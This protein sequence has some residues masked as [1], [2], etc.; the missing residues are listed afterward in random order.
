[1]AILATKNLVLAYEKKHVIQ[2]LSIDIEPG[3]FIGLIGPNGAGK[4]TFL[5]SISGQFQ[6]KSGSVHFGE[7][8][9]YRENYQYKKQIGYVH[10]N[11]FFYLGFGRYLA[12]FDG[13]SG[14]AH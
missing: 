4:T 1:M 14:A 7:R 5:L 3:T 13:N 8:D 12:I 10:E 6:P 9:I 11:P 2:D